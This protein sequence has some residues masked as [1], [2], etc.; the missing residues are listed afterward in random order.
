MTT[1][2][3][4]L[5]RY[6]TM[7]VEA[8]ARTLISI[9][10]ITDLETFFYSKAAQSPWMVLGGGSN[11]LFISDFPGTILKMDIREQRI[12]PLDEHHVLVKAGGG[13]SWPEFVAWALE[14]NLG[15]LENL[16]LIPGT[17]GAAPIQNIG[18]YGVELKDRMISL[19]AFD[20]EEL[21]MVRFS[22]DDCGFDYRFS[23]FKGKWKGRHVITS[24]TFRL[25]QKKHSLSTS[26]GAIASELSNIAEPTIQDVARAVIRIRQSKLPNPQEL[27][28]TGSFFKNPII[29][30]DFFQQIRLNFPNI[31]AYPVDEQR[32]KVPAAWLIDQCAWK[33]KRH[34]AVGCYSQQP[35]VIVHYGGANGAE[36]WAFAQK[37]QKSVL[38]KFGINLE[39]E[40]NLIGT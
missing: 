14:Q 19:E 24:V 38:D 29:N 32:V 15:G 23:H 10:Q 20:T 18:A 1:K 30:Q 33:G 5:L 2:A 17:V 28:N 3:I 7:G 9:Q 34:G 31:P 11:V 8:A 16:S 37:V 39:P 22:K 12:Q 35:L 6:N 26:Y 13:E 27:G 40:V 21:K 25:T 4:S 36:V